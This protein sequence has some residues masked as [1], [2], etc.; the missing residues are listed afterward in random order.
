MADFPMANAKKPSRFPLWVLFVSAVNYMVVFV[1]ASFQLSN[2]QWIYGQMCGQ[3]SCWPAHYEI[4]AIGLAFGAFSLIASLVM[5]FLYHR[6]ARFKDMISVPVSALIAVLWLVVLVVGWLP[7]EISL[8][9]G[10]NGLPAWGL[11]GANS[12]TLSTSYNSS[13]PQPRAGMFHYAVAYRT[14][15]L[16]HPSVANNT[17]I[18]VTVE[19]GRTALAGVIVFTLSL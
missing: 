9:A 10:H 11:N 6:D 17:L 19:R 18:D 8:E 7:L 16:N 5:F 3:G 2:G 13:D 12:T 15:T 14:A 4:W 1:T